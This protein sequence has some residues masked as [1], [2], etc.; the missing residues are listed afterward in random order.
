MTT[1]GDADGRKA[2]LASPTILTSTHQL[3]NLIEDALAPIKKE[4]AN[5]PNSDYIN[6]VIEKLSS[7]L[8]ERFEIQDQKINALEARVDVLE[9][10]LA[11]LDALDARIE[12]NEQYSRRFCLRFHGIPLPA[13]GNKEDCV[14]KVADIMENMD[15]GVGKEA[16]DR[17]HR[18]G[19]VT[20]DKHGKP[21]QQ[22]IVRFKA[23]SERTAVYR[24]RK[25]AGGG[26]RVI[27][28]LTKKRLSLLND[29]ARLVES[30][31]CVDFVFADINCNT[32]TKLTEG[33]FLFFKSI[34]KLEEKL[35]DLIDS[36]DDNGQA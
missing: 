18:I 6:A 28:D 16:I 8:E 33:K 3:K 31:G 1:T 34:S 22:V 19:R 27:L 2:T 29:A 25:N 4:I 15:C 20:M 36:K 26:V 10:K 13:D 24:S 9:S 7:K 21:S 30:M 12:E 5:L 35:R 17:A 14:Q 23:L 32:V 11:V